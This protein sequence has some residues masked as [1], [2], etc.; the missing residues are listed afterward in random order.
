MQCNVMANVSRGN[1]TEAG[2]RTPLRRLNVF[3]QGVNNK[4]RMFLI[5]PSSKSYVCARA[6]KLS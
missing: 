6:M 3:L 1:E 4:L 2:K 5:T